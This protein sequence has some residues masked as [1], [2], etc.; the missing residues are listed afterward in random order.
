LYDVVVIGAGIVGACTV[1]ELSRLDISVCLIEKENDAAAGAT[2]ANSA[3]VHAGFDPEEGTLMARFNVE[4][5]SMFERLSKEAGFPYKRNGALVLAFS[6]E[7]LDTIGMLYKRGVA[8]GVKGLR[9]ID[10]EELLL[11]EPNLGAQVSGALLAPSAGIVG[12]WEMC[13]A[14]IVK[15]ANRGVSLRFRNAV[16]GIR[17][18]TDF[19]EIEINGGESQ[20]Q[21]KR[22]VNAAGIHAD[23][24]MEMAGEKEF[25]ILPRKGQYY[26]LDK[27]QGTLVSHT[28]FQCPSDRGKGVMVTPTV[29][30]NLLVGPDS[31]PAEGKEDKATSREGL[32]VVKESALRSVESINF[33]DT[34]RNYAGLRAYSDRKDFII[35]ESASVK[36]LINLAGIKSPGLTAAPAIAREALRLLEATGL[37]MAPRPEKNDPEVRAKYSEMNDEEKQAVIQENPAYGRVICRCEGITE[38]EIIESL[39]GPLGAVS[40]D[41]VKRRVRPGSGRCQGGF[42]GP[43]VIE[44]ISRELDIK[45]WEVPLD[46]DGSYVLGGEEDGS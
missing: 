11:L 8:N 30:G 19:F 12:P 39:K 20:V 31:G 38:G 7:D 6:E 23:E 37:H 41:G 35:E 44:I 16:T 29:H 27:S 4:G 5:C 10:R 45:P 22:I 3:L 21:A 42:C 36:G 33:R 1:Y 43:K 13:M 18:T 40:Q 28:L 15:A 25:A 14:L 17:K 9:I 24:I 26:V 34:I 46:L 2:K 32:E